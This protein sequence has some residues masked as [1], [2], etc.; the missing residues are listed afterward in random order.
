MY[1]PT[2][3]PLAL[4]VFVLIG[5]LTAPF[6]GL[7]TRRMEAE[8][9]WV[10]LRTTERPVT[11]QHLFQRLAVTSRAQPEPPAWAHVLLDNHPTIMQRIEMSEAWRQRNR[12]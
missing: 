12:P 10:A 5:L 9:D 7:V 3:I 11:A 8:A 2:A 6:Q 1:E 4:L